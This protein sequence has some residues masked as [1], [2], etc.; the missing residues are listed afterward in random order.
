MLRYAMIALVA[1]GLGAC[2]G[3]PQQNQDN[4]DQVFGKAKLALVV[5]S[6]AVALYNVGC[7]SAVVPAS[8]CT[9]QI[10][11]IVNNVLAGAVDAVDAAEKVFADINSTQD[12]RLAA[13]K[14]SMTLVAELQKALEKYGL[15]RTTG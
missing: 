5:G 2:G 14:A 13:A 4:A 9:K 6:G 7:M 10:M 15:R 1:I 11:T 3:T 8:I 12:A